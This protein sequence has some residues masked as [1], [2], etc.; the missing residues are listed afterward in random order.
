MALQLEGFFQLRGPMISSFDVARAELFES[1]RG[2]DG[3][4][5]RAEL[6]EVLWQDLQVRE[7]IAER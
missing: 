1:C 6:A 5:G 7:R 3:L 4:L 2:A